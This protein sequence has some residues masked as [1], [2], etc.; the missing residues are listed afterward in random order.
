MNSRGTLLAGL[1]AV[2][3]QL[4]PTRAQEPDRERPPTEAEVAQLRHDVDAKREELRK[5]EERLER[6]IRDRA[7]R[8]GTSMPPGSFP[9]LPSSDR[10]PFNM[11]A[12]APPPLPSG[13][14]GLSNLPT[15]VAPSPRTWPTLPAETSTQAPTSPERRLEQL[16]QKVGRLLEG[17]EE[18]RREVRDLKGR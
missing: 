9:P 12:P 7:S 6:A 11:D 15:P 16:E 17:M 5:A 4:P 13:H 8:A 3:M 1:L 18:L 2:A 14:Q 10:S